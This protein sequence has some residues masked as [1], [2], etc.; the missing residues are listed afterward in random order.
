MP[1]SQIRHHT[2][3]YICSLIFINQIIKLS[4]SAGKKET[5][6]WLFFFKG[7]RTVPLSPTLCSA[8]RIEM[9]IANVIYNVQN[10][11]RFWRKR[12]LY[13]VVQKLRSDLTIKALS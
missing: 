11:L 3:I 6:C 2:P 9:Q 1:W 4:V 8:A 10:N 12:G 5:T 7:K 13:F